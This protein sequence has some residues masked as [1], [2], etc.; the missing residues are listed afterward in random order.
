VLSGS[1][2]AADLSEAG[3]WE[4]VENLDQLGELQG[5]WTNAVDDQ[6]SD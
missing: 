4:T 2:S 5:V 6:E 1:A 3:A